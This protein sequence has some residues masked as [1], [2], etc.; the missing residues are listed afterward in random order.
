MSTI[1]LLCPQ[2]LNLTIQ[3][4]NGIIYLEETKIHILNNDN[5]E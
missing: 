2:I 5:K 4:F 3:N 1:I